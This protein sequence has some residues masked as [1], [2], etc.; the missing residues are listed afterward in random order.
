MGTSRPLAPLSLLGDGAAAAAVARAPAAAAAAEVDPEDL[1]ILQPLGQ[2]ALQEVSPLAGPF[3]SP[4]PTADAADEANDG[5]PDG[6]VSW[7]ALVNV[8]A[9]RFIKRVTGVRPGDRVLLKE[10]TAG[11]AQLARNEAAVYERLQSTTVWCGA[12][13]GSDA[14]TDLPILVLRGKFETLDTG[15]GDLPADKLEAGEDGL[16]TSEGNRGGPAGSSGR[17]AAFDAEDMSRTF[18]RELQRRA[19]LRLKGNAADAALPPR[20]RATISTWLVFQWE[21]IHPAADFAAVEQTPGLFGFLSQRRALD[22]RKKFLKAVMVGA[23]E[24]LAFCH[25]R[26]V[27]H[28]AVSTGCLLLSSFNEED[29]GR[30]RVKMANFGLGA[31]L[32]MGV[33]GLEPEVREACREMGAETPLDVA[34][35]LRQIDRHYLGFALAELVFDSLSTEGPS[36]RTSQ[37]AIQRL[38]ESVFSCDM[39]AVREYCSEEWAWTNAVAFLDEGGCAGWELLGALLGSGEGGSNAEADDLLQSLAMA[40]FGGHRGR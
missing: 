33:E 28:G 6:G 18:E 40:R 9:A 21:G 3:F 11:A 38:W 7:P 14:G 29:Y 10:Y 32:S 20:R 13:E 39:G 37:C 4:E 15:L 5:S 17:E 12:G 1:E 19:E 27:V 24:A 25:V 36:E 8:Y 30:V 2:L 16:L 22:R 23:L 34:A 26:G 31:D 35:M